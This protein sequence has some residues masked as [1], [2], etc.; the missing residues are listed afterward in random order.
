VDGWAGI[1]E[2]N[3]DTLVMKSGE[4]IVAEKLITRYFQ[5]YVWAD[6]RLWPLPTFMSQVKI[7]DKG[8]EPKRTRVKSNNRK[9]LNWLPKLC[10]LENDYFPVAVS[11]L[12]MKKIS[13]GISYSPH[14]SQSLWILPDFFF[15][16]AK[17]AHANLSHLD[18]RH[19]T[20][21][22]IAKE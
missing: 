22:E 13:K 11:L 10:Y 4:L 18:N 6:D 9:L 5:Y 19:V 7:I 3:K 15:L 20:P 14:S 12:I 2:C 8:K 17:Q 1:P 21:V 16:C